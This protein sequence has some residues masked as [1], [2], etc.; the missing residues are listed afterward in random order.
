M[1]IPFKTILFISLVSCT[2][3]KMKN[4]SNSCKMDSI[5]IKF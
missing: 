1:K 4:L 2:Q 3:E 5:V